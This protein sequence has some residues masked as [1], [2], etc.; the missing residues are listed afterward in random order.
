MDKLIGELMKEL[1]R[2][3]LRDRTLVVFTGDNGTAVFGVK[4]AT[5]HGKH[6]SGRKARMLEGGSRVPLVAYWPGHTLA[7]QVNDDLIDFSDFLATFAELAGTKLPNGVTLDSHSFAPQILGQKGQPRQWVYVELDGSSYARD[8]RFKLTN[9]GQLYDL[10]EA[11]YKEILVDRDMANPAAITAR[12]KLQ[13][14]LDAHPAA[15]K[16]TVEKKTIPQL[17]GGTH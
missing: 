9:R 5:V 4:I 1:D 8:G 16:K 11:P 14:V 10:A 6:I 3:H 2:Q 17:I 12:K 15:R 7:G 13:A